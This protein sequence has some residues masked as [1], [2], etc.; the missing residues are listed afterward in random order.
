MLISE[1]MNENAQLDEITR[2]ATLVNAGEILEKAGYKHIGKGFFAQVYS[3]TGSDYVLKL[4][5]STDRAYMAFVRTAMRTKNIHFPVFKGKMMR[6]NRE[7]YAVRMEKLDKLFDR[8][9]YSVDQAKEAVSTISL[10]LDDPTLSYNKR[11]M[12]ELEKTQPG[13]TEACNILKNMMETLWLRS[14]IGHNNLMLRGNV[15]V[16]TDPVV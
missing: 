12:E 13:I 5:R 15:L 7:Y 1:L 10:Y 14:D 16:I 3:R 11:R 8:D 4:F 9:A 6:V 2:P